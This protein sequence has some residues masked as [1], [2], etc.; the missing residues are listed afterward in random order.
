MTKMDEFNPFILPSSVALI[1]SGL[2]FSHQTTLS[3]LSTGDPALVMFPV[4]RF[5][6]V[7]VI[8]GDSTS[9]SRQSFQFNTQMLFFE[10]SNF[11]RFAFH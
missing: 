2:A 4:F 7:D 3:V 6:I 5:R 10:K 8:S 11:D 9:S 1:Q